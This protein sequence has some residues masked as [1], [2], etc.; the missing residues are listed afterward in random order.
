V[1]K[2]TALEKA[3]AA[4]INA[5]AREANA[6]AKAIEVKNETAALLKDAV[7]D[8]AT[9]V[10]GSDWVP[11][12]DRLGQKKQLRRFGHGGILVKALPTMAAPFLVKNGGKKIPDEFW[13]MEDDEA[14]V[15]CPCGNEPHIGLGSIHI[16]QGED[17]G[18]VFF[19]IGR[20]VRIT[21]LSDE[22]KAA[23][24]SPANE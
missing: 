22:D 5:D 19:F 3:E 15:A 1:S 14:V 4:K 11:P 18:R 9:G 6:R 17:C 21:T 12:E 23:L 16:C 20:E 24:A 10:S 7:A 13:A 2:P 8:L